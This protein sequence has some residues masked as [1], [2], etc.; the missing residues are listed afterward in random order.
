MLHELA[1]LGVIFL[2]FTV[3]LHISLKNILQREV[4]GVG[5]IHLLISVAIFIPV[6]LYFGL[7]LEA[8]IIIAITL[9]FS[10]T[11]LAAKGLET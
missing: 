5:L 8:S 10:S 4:L 9:G 3:G 6:S 7:S 2:L 11:V 1:H